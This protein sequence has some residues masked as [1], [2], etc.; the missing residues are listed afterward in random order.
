MKFELCGSPPWRP[1]KVGTEAD[2]TFKFSSD[3]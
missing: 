1:S 2:P 3:I